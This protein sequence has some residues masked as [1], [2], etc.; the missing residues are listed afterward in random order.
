M[1]EFER[2]NEI[3]VERD[4]AQLW[5]RYVKPLRA[6][7]GLLTDGLEL[8]IYERRNGNPERKLHV[9]LGEITLSQCEEIYDWLKKPKLEIAEVNEVLGYFERFDK[10][11]RKIKLSEEADIAQ[12]HFFE[13]FEL[14]E[15][16]IF[17]N[18]VQATIGLFDFELERS[19]F[20]KSAYNF[21]KI[22]YAKKP[23]KVPENWRRIMNEIGLEANEENL[24]KFMFCLE[25]A[26]SL[27][28]RL[29]LAKACED[30]KLPYVEFSRFIK[31]RIENIGYSYRGTVPL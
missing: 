1:I 10:P 30:Y 13:C 15:G 29:I 18:L 11:E 4:F 2:P 27:F 5:E 25:S 8:L 16:S 9:N 31:T 7:Y 23:E 24:L 6:K 28:T 21:W 19:K 3:D 12:E 26:Y 22:S 17:V 20:L 14:K